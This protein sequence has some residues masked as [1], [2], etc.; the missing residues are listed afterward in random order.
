MSASVTAAYTGLKQTEPGLPSHFYYDPEHHQRELRAIWYR[1]W[2]YAFRAD[3]V[4]EPQSFRTVQ[5]G[6][7]NILVVRD[8][9]GALHAFHNTCRHRGSVLCAEHE[10]R[11]RSKFIVCPYHGW[12][13]GLD[14]ALDTVP[15]LGITDDFDRHDYPLYRVAVAE[16][17]GSVFI[18][19]E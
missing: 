10:G 14:G 4:K 15:G 2:M 1:N 12:G 17:G 11:L 13:Y 6:D 3:Q 18:R 16:W 5:I 19:L 8:E 7:Q 9:Q